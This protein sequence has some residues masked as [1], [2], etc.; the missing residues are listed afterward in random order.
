M[1]ETVSTDRYLQITAYASA[2]GRGNIVFSLLLEDRC[3]RG[4]LLGDGFR[5]TFSEMVEV[6]Q[7]FQKRRSACAVKPSSEAFLP[8]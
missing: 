2:S 5:R 4:T 8:Q 3:A 7:V 1:A 6:T